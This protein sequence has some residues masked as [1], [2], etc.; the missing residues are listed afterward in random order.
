MSVL[1]A[2]QFKFKEV[3]DI[4]VSDKP[5]PEAHVVRQR[6]SRPEGAYNDDKYVS[7]EHSRREQEKMHEK[8]EQVAFDRLMCA[9]AV[10]RGRRKQKLGKLRQQ[11]L[12]KKNY[13]KQIEERIQKILHTIE[14]L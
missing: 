7:E 12:D 3:F 9:V 5:F 14:M 10:E 6:R 13:M 4:S 11:T 1:K 8:C 2:P